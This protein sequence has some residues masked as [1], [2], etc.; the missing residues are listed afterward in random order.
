VAMPE[1][2]GGDSSRRLGIARKAE[3]PMVS[4]KGVVGP[5][6][7]LR[8]IEGDEG[9]RKEGARMTLC[10]SFGESRGYDR[11][12]ARLQRELVAR[13]VDERGGWLLYDVRMPCGGSVSVLERSGPQA[14]E[15]DVA[16]TVQL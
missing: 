4:R 16:A 12:P 7:A 3:K 8:V 13:G 9:R 14:P 15:G 11:Q 10:E 5:G 2:R 6:Y 1:G